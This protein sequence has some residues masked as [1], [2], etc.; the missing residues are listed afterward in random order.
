MKKFWVWI[1]VLIIGVFIMSFSLIYFSNIQYRNDFSNIFGSDKCLFEVINRN[2]FKFYTLNNKRV[3]G[4]EVLE[5]YMNEHGFSNCPDE[6][7][8]TLHYFVNEEGE[9]I[10]CEAEHFKNYIMWD[11]YLEGDRGTVP[12]PPDKTS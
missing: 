9:Y 11:I 4:F 5:K 8:G 2:H 6:Q 7:L 12:L 10:E 1:S 3:S